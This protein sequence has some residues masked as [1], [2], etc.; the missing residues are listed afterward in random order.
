MA[1]P[2]VNGGGA[3]REGSVEK[4]RAGEE[5]INYIKVKYAKPLNGLLLV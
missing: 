1:S 2:V 3:D 5:P 4:E